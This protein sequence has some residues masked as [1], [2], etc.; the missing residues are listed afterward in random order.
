[1]SSVFYIF[2]FTFSSFFFPLFI[3]PPQKK[4][5]RLIF[6]QGGCV[7]LLF[8]PC[9]QSITLALFVFRYLYSNSLSHPPVSPS[10]THSSLAQPL[11]SNSTR[12]SPA[13]GSLSKRNKNNAVTL[14][15]GVHILVKKRYLIP[16]S[17]RKLYF[18]PCR[19]MSFIDYFCGLFALI[20]PCFAFI[21]HVFFPFYLILSPSS[22]FFPLSSFFFH[23][24]PSFSLPLFIFFPPNDIG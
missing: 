6:S 7:F 18:S 11:N 10:N 15:A 19:D 21:S 17:F 16:P 2:S 14:R 3:S 22:F 23:I 9:S 4:C 5:H 8:T 13:S 1:M 20:L 24:F 12:S